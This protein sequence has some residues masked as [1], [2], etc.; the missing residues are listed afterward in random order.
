M[1]PVCLSWELWVCR[2]LPSTVGHHPML[3]WTDSALPIGYAC[4]HSP[5]L[6]SWK[7]GTSS[8]L[9]LIPA[10]VIWRAKAAFPLPPR[11]LKW[12]PPGSFADW[13]GFVTANKNLKG[14]SVSLLLNSPWCHSPHI[15][16][17]ILW[18]SSLPTNLAQCLANLRPTAV[19]P[20]ET[21]GIIRG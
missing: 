19:C 15:N 7:G 11:R 20:G 17:P 10:V 8:Y 13:V 1:K 5:W 4:I 21:T 14:H 18:S 6:S 2:W 3:S 16:A 12:A 9:A